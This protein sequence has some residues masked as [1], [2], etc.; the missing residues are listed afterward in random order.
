MHTR[1]PCWMSVWENQVHLARGT[2]AIKS[3][4]IFTGSCS[5]VRP[6]SVERRCTWVST[7]TPSLFPKAVPSTTLAVLRPSPGSCTSS[8]M[9][10]GTVPPCRSQGLR[11]A[12]DRLRL[13]AEES[14]AVNLLLEEGGIRGG[15][16]PR[17][18][19]L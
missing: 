4:S 9:V 19:V 5:F 7:T 10:A 14:G 17:G 15:V 8:Y 11:H 6:S 1:R 2:S 13:V 18:A 3:R 12:E 16:I